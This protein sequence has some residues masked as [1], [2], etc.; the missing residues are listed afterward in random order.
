MSTLGRVRCWENP[1]GSIRV[2]HYIA[3]EMKKKGEINPDTGQIMDHDETEDEFIE[4]VDSKIR[5]TWSEYRELPSALEK[6]T[7]LPWSEPREKWRRKDGRIHVD[8][9]I[10]TSSEIRDEKIKALRNKLS[11]L[12]LSKDEIDLIVK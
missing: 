7:D 6:V 1:D 8:H 2:T 4:R 12:G 3:K 9:S 11:I 5:K 10:K